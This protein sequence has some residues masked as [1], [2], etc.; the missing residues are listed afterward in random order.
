M[1]KHIYREQWKRRNSRWVWGTMAYLI[2][3]DSPMIL[4]LFGNA[5]N[6]EKALFN[7]RFN[8]TKLFRPTCNNS[9]SSMSSRL[10][11][12]AFGNNTLYPSNTG[13]EVEEIDFPADYF[14]YHLGDP[15][16]YFSTIPLLNFDFRQE[17]TIYKKNESA[18]I[19]LI[20]MV[21]ETVVKNKNLP[22]YLSSNYSKLSHNFSTFENFKKSSVLVNTILTNHSTI[23]SHER[24]IPSKSYILYPLHLVLNSMKALL[25]V[26]DGWVP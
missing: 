7:V 22:D 10:G 24:R 21:A 17:S 12:K 16:T 18:W 2:N 20:R 4:N 14:I 26:M 19:R 25:S 5:T 23:R 15:N 3:M 6:D 11:C 13:Y 8:H 1:Y 9:D